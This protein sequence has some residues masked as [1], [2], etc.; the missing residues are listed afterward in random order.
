MNIKM[1]ALYLVSVVHVMHWCLFT[2]LIIFAK[3]LQSLWFG[4]SFVFIYAP[5][6]ILGI[7]VIFIYYTQYVNKDE[8][9]SGMEARLIILVVL[10]ISLKIMYFIIG[11][12]L[13]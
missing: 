3:G 7:I 6:S 10:S 11:A 9:I 4:Y 13:A 12:I 5:T 8:Y 1:Y 2:W